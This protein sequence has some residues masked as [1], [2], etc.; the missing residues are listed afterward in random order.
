MEVTE[1]ASELILIAIVYTCLVKSGRDLLLVAQFEHDDDD[2]ALWLRSDADSDGDKF[3][4]GFVVY[5]LNEEEQNWVPMNSLD[6]RVLFVGNGCSF[7]IFAQDFPGCKRNCTYYT[8]NC[9]IE[10]RNQNENDYPG[11]DVALCLTCPVVLQSH[12]QHSLAILNYFG[13][14]QSGL[15][16]VLIL[17][18]K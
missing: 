10:M 13:L 15:S 2:F 18:E 3:N 16:P 6:D 12:Y 9:I 7:S 5:K 17:C 14:L 11:C 1:V 8:K 4:C